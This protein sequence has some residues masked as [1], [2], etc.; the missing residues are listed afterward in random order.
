MGSNFHLTS[1]HISW[2]LPENI[3]HFHVGPMWK[4]FAYLAVIEHKHIFE[5]YILTKL[6]LNSNFEVKSYLVWV[7]YWDI[8]EDSGLQSIRLWGPT[9]GHFEALNF[10]TLDLPSP[11]G[12]K[13]RVHGMGGGNIHT[14]TY[15]YIYI[16]AHTHPHDLPRVRSWGWV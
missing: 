2:S 5:N 15:I 11:K 6:Y 14:H 4:G 9:I 12:S 3:S 13:T 8:M 16:Y 10:E 7:S 1:L